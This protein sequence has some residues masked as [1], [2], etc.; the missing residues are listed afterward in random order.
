MSDLACPGC[1]RQEKLLRVNR[2]LARCTE[3][4]R[5]MVTTGFGGLERLDP[6]LPDEYRALTLAQIGIRVGDVVS[7]RDKHYLITEAA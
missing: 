7:A 5:R 4:N 3:C 1:G 6:N 2:P